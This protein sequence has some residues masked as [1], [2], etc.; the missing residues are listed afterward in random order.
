VY[1]RPR[2]RSKAS[3][4]GRESGIG[5]FGQRGADDPVGTAA[6]AATAITLADPWVTRP[7]PKARPG[8]RTVISAGGPPSEIRRSEW[9]GPSSRR[10]GRP[11]ARMCSGRWSAGGVVV[12]RRTLP[13]RPSHVEVPNVRRPIQRNVRGVRRH[14]F[15]RPVRFTTAWLASL[16]AANRNPLAWCAATGRANQVGTSAEI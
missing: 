3:V 1:L 4:P 12:C 15:D 9:S 2:S 8:P 10:A 14:P 11:K 5:R 6:P 16:I 13:D 7:A